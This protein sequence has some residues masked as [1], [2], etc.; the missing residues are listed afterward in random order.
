M[1]KRHLSTYNI[2]MDI[3]SQYLISLCHVLPSNGEIDYGILFY[4]YPSI[5]Y[6]FQLQVNLVIILLQHL[7]QNDLFYTITQSRCCF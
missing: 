7:H 2:L 4:I 1:V 5:L 3:I 6:H